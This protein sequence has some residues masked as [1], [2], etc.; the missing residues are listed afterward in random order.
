MA[1]AREILVALRRAEDRSAHRLLRGA[2]ERF[3]PRPCPAQC[4]CHGLDECALRRRG[5][6]APSRVRAAA[7]RAASAASISRPAARRRWCACAR[8]C[9]TRWII[10]TISPPSTT[11]FVHLFSSWFNRGF[12]VLRRIDWSTPANLWRRSSATRRCTRSATGTTCARRIDPPDRRCYAFFHPAL[13][14]EPLIFV[15][16]ALTRDIPGGDRRRSCRAKRERDRARARDDGGVLFDLQLPARARRRLVRQFPDQ[17]GGRGGGARNPAAVDLRHA[18]RR[19]RTLPSGSSA[20]AQ[21]EASLALSEEDRAAL[22]DARPRRTGGSD[23]GR[24][25]DGARAAAARG[26]VVLSA[27]AHA[28]RH[29]AR[30]G[31]ALPSRQRRAARAAQLRSPTRRSGRCGN[32]TA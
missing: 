23:A 12:L 17:A 16:V 9:S 2:G 29:A 30:F 4:R 20:S 14:D 5:V 32:R 3:R 18:C 15:E 13:V 10:A 28:A 26:G 11:T 31:R 8:S 21:A 24:R 6:Q 22:A 1:L 7:A 25:R 27:R 19:R